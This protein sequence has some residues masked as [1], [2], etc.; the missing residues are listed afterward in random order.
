MH[1]E[2]KMH[3]KF[4]FEAKRPLGRLKY[5]Y[6]DNIKMNFRGIE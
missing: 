2:L 1:E 6:A 4:W 5:K 3:I